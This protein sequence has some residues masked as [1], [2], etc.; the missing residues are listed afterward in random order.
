MLTA[1]LIASSLS[2]DPGIH[3][4]HEDQTKEPL[5]NLN[6]SS[7][8]FIRNQSLEIQERAKSTQLCRHLETYAEAMN[9]F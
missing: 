6:I 5:S 8:T 4:P 1:S 2:K 7:E 3:V 9:E